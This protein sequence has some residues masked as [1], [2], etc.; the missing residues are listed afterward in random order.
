MLL[1]TYP[2]FSVK[3]KSWNQSKTQSINNAKQYF[4]GYN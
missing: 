3:K 4:D 2:K 1:N